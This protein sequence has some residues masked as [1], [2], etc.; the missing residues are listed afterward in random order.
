MKKRDV[1][2]GVVVVLIIIIILAVVLKSLWEFLQEL[3]QF[4]LLPLSAPEAGAI[5]GIGVAV[6]A[7]ALI[8]ILLGLITIIEFLLSLP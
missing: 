6:F 4:L 8:L 5:A 3:T 2:A 1:A 7:F